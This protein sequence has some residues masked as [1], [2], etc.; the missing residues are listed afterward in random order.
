V[1]ALA[2]GRKLMV[3]GDMGE[4][5]PDAAELHAGIGE[6]ARAAGVNRLYTLGELSLRAAQSFGEGARHFAQVDDLAAA[7]KADLSPQTTV[8]VKGSRF[9]RMERVV[10]ALSAESIEGR[11]SRD[12][13]KA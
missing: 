11:R 10:D 7:V 5:G 6:A 1:L 9:M 4:L 12:G 3:L 2:T 8:L 13:E